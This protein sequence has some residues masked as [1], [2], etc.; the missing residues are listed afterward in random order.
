MKK[1]IFGVDIGGTSI[2]IGFFSAVGDLLSDWEIETR[3]E[4]NG[5]NILPDIAEAIFEKLEAEGVS[6]DDVIGI[7]L[8]APGPV[9]KDGTIKGAVNLGWGTF[10]IKETL[11]SLTGMKVEA[12]NDANVAALGEMWKGGGKGY[13]DIMMVTLGTGVGGGLII[14]GKIHTGA[15][16]AGAEIGHM[17]VH[18]PEEEPNVCGCGKRGCFEQYTS[19][20][21]VISIAKRYLESN[22]DKPCGLRDIPDFTSKELFDLV[23]AGDAAACEIAEII[24]RYLGK[25]LANVAAITDVEAFVIGGGMSKAGQVIIDG[26]KKYYAIYAFSPTRNVEFKL[27]ALGN[28]AGIYGAAKLVIA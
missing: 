27:A 17:A 16:G 4:D 22:P 5:K 19:A 3:T 6:K 8:D 15:N 2:K 7:G 11:S 21:G 12:G 28:K 9:L 26:I 1:Y 23:K 24:Y 25:G 10:N 18:D 13:S 14:D 20:R